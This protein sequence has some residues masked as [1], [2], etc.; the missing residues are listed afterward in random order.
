M[1]LTLTLDGSFSEI[2]RS[3]AAIENSGVMLSDNDQ[4]RSTDVGAF[5]QSL[6]WNGKK[7]VGQLVYVLLNNQVD[8]PLEDRQITRQKWQEICGFGSE[9][10]NGVLGSVGRAWAKHSDEPNPFVSQGIDEDGNHAHGI[11]DGALLHDLFKL[12][13][14]PDQAE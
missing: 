8:R 2:K 11:Q 10:F 7:A 6:A 14:K 3:I 4:P 12:L 9:E 13:Y 1:K 5:V